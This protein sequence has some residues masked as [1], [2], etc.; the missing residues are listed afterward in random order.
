MTK[1][2]EF[3]LPKTRLE[4]FPLNVHQLT[5]GCVLV[6]GYQYEIDNEIYSYAIV[7]AESDDFSDQTSKVAFREQPDVIPLG[8]S[9]YP[10]RMEDAEFKLVDYPGQ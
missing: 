10:E 1:L 9:D 8:T 6:S 5:N 3:D 4:L 2:K 7:S